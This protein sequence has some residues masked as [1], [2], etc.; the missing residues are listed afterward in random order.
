MLNILKE[1]YYGNLDPIGNTRPK[2]KEYQKKDEQYSKNRHAFEEA[3][4]NLDPNLFQTFSS[5]CSQNSCLNVD[6]EA[7]A[8]QLGFCLGVSIMQEV[9]RRIEIFS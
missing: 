8:F 4:E 6:E 5:L 3:L 1:L 9:S 2:S 7:E